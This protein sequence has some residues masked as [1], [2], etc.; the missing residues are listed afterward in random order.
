MTVQ[1]FDT[2]DLVKYEGR[3][4]TFADLSAR[5]LADDPTGVT[6]HLGVTD[7]NDL[8][9]PDRVTVTYTVETAK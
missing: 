3:T 1:R 9:R 4:A 5:R 2:L 6:V 8:G 7:W